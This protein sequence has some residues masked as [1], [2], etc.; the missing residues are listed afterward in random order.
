MLMRFLRIELWTNLANNVF[1]V[2][3]QFPTLDYSHGWI[4]LFAFAEEYIRT[5]VTRHSSDEYE[6]FTHVHTSKCVYIVTFVL[7]YAVAS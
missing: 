6:L 1:S 7:R 4:P 2:A 5:K 3:T